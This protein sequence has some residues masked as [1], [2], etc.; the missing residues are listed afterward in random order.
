MKNKFVKLMLYI[1][2]FSILILSL[3]GC[4]KSDDSKELQEKIDAELSYLDTKLVAMLN[5][6]NGIS[7][8]NY[9]VKADE[10]T[11]KSQNGEDSGGSQSSNGGA[12]SE[13]GGKSNSSSEG[14]SSGNSSSGGSSD[15][16]NKNSVK[17]SMEGNEI[18]L[19][20]RT[21]DWN[22]VKAEIEKL[23]CSWSTVMLDLYKVNTNNQDILNFNTDLDIATRQYKK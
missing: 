4:N 21:P 23:Y 9:I 3:T 6:V 8:E 22:T 20:E 2:I 16:D 13:E 12:S 11:T 17:Y 14:T 1:V 10:I 19:Q 5:K 7:Y 15:Q 18:L